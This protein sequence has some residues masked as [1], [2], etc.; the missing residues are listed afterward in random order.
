MKLSNETM[1]L[2]KNFAL[3][4]S[5]IVIGAGSK[6]KTINEA[7]NV[8]GYA[9]IAE[10]FPVEFGIYDLGEFLNV[11]NMF[12]DP[13][14]E[15]DE[16]LQSVVIS[17]GKRLVRYRFSNTEILTSVTK[18]VKMPKAD[19]AFHLSSDDLAA[20]R[21]ATSVLGVSDVV[22]TNNGEDSLLVTTTDV[23]DSSS[24]R[25]AIEIPCEGLSDTEFNLIF[26]VSNF[27][28]VQGDYDIEVSSKLISKFTNTAANVN[29]FI[30]LEK[31]STYGE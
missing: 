6:L 16:K 28:M 24:N 11:Y 22:I 25:F 5:N 10:T 3:I 8:M 29:Y 13:E 9:D 27:K 18:E 1:S 12:D 26:N 20:I 19:L 17:Q 15:F 31:S 14:L 7:K 4:N 21:K 2:L 23:K 30:A